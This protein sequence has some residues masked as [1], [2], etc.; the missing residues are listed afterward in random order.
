MAA[1]TKLI[2]VIVSLTLLVFSFVTVS[3]HL[4][5]NFYARTCPNVQTIVH[6]TM[7]QAV[8][9][10]A[11]MGASILR[12]FFHD[13]F[14]QGC[15]GSVLLDDTATFTGEK[16]AIPNVNSLRGFEVIDTIKAN[17]EAACKATVSCADI[18]AL[19]A[20]DGVFL[21][22]GPKWDVL[23]GR[24]DSTTASLSGANN[25]LPSPFVD[26][27]VIISKFEKKGLNPTDMTALSGAHTIGR[28]RC[29]LF[30]NRIYGETNIDPKFAALRR[31]TCPAAAGHGD[32]NLA[33]IDFQTPTRFD[34]LYYKNLV[35]E[36]GLFHSDQVLFNNG[37]QD[38]LVR[39]YSAGPRA[40]KRDFVAA[41]IKMG[42][43]GPLT[44]ANGQIRL[45][46]RVVN[47]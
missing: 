30:R 23:L 45:N 9:K 26:L 21:L 31:A 34:N 25:D 6:T 8:S 19:A 35:A 38:A 29:L 28:G 42:N 1:S 47:P 41:M 11:R 5:R 27:P 10:E 7:R 17:V 2:F 18:V 40:F 36:R 16:T 39:T 24:R 14:V 43:I 13:C 37:S 32:S 20:R 46:C 22:G 15:D 3:A 44:G 33:P 4:S 12:L